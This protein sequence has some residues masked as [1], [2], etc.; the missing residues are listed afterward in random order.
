MG[1]LSGSPFFFGL[2][3]A[4]VLICRSSPLAPHRS[5][6][7]GSAASGSSLVARTR[8]VD[9]AQLVKNEDLVDRELLDGG[10]RGLDRLLGLA[11]PRKQPV[12]LGRVEAVP[13]VLVGLARLAGP[14]V[15]VTPPGRSVRRQVTAVRLGQRP[16]LRL[17]GG[18]PTRLVVL[19][20]RPT[21][22]LLALRFLQRPPAPRRHTEAFGPDTR[23]SR[24][25][26]T[27]RAISTVSGGPC[28]SQ[29][30]TTCRQSRPRS[31]AT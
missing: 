23:T 11:R 31:L 5:G 7:A 26:Q 15:L 16:I 27:V 12:I 9:L 25:S 19:F 24:S 21:E 14:A 18:Q 22:P 20:P 17:F 10:R 29:A 6:R 2:R 30:I 8:R 3:P 13:V 4:N 1:D 28:Q